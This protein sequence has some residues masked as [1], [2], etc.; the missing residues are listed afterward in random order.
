MITDDL[1]VA[2]HQRSALGQPLSDEERQQLQA[3][4]DEKDREEAQMLR[5]SSTALNL[6]EMVIQMRQM[7]ALITELTRQNNVISK[8]N[9]SLLAE[10]V[11]LRHQL[12]G[13]VSTQPG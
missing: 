4:Y 11:A 3:W 2:L 10:I 13:R 5:L 12:G 6:A 1:G 9:E 7:I 8:Q